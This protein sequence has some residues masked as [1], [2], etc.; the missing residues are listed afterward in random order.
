MKTVAEW[1]NLL[2]K[3]IRFKPTKEDASLKALTLSQAIRK[4]I[5]WQDTKE[6]F[7][8]WS[9]MRDAFELSEQVTNKNK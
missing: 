4:G 8:F 1:V 3:E 9:Q 6:G 5:R 7:D 2:P